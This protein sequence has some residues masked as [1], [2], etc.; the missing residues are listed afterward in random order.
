VC[1]RSKTL[2]ALGFAASR[3]VCVCNVCD[4][5]VC[6]LWCVRVC[7]CAGG[8]LQGHRE[9]TCVCVHL[10]S[11]TLCALEFAA[12]R[13]VCNVCVCV[14]WCMCMRVVVCACV[15]VCAGGGL[16]GHREPA[17]VCACASRPCVLW[18]LQQPGVCV[19]VMCVMCVY[20]CCGVCV[21][22]CVCGR[23]LAGP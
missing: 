19:C 4:V 10:R 21:R 9:S 11:K 1:L 18:G 2:C 3:C 13:C 5:C 15:C 22:V 7:V 23:R 12:A 6:V 20:A 14:L 17:C 8:G 16:Q